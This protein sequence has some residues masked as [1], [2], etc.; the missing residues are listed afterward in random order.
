MMAP[1]LRNGVMYNLRGV[2]DIE[3]SEDAI[4][5]ATQ[6]AVA[7]VRDVLSMYDDPQRFSARKKQW[8]SEQSSGHL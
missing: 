4:H 8:Q 7:K 5:C 1:E 3:I 2:G 6:E